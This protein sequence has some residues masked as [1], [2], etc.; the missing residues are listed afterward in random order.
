VK[1]GLRVTRFGCSIVF[2]SLPAL[3]AAQTTAI[4][5]G[6]FSAPEESIGWLEQEIAAFQQSHP[7]I[8]VSV[9]NLA[10]PLR[11]RFQ[12]HEDFFGP[13]VEDV[14]GANVTGLDG[15]FGYLAPYLAERG[16]IASISRFDAADDSFTLSDFYSTQLDFVRFNGET[17]AVPWLA[18]TPLLVI[19]VEV[20]ER[21]G[22]TQAPRT[23]QEFVDVAEA[24]T[25]DTNND[26]VIDQ[27]GVGYRTTDE[28]TP[29]LFM[30]LVLQLDGQVL[31]EGRFDGGDDAVA[32][33]VGFMGKLG[34]AWGLAREDGRSL[35]ERRA[36]PTAR[37]A[38]HLETNH[39]LGAAI[40]DSGLRLAPM[41]S[42]D[43]TPKIFA[44]WRQY[45]AVRTSTPAQEAA[46]W[47]FVKWMTRR[48][49]SMPATLAGFPARKDFTSR[50]DFRQRT[51]GGIQNAG[52]IFDS[53]GDASLSLD[54]V[55]DIAP[56]AERFWQIMVPAIADPAKTPIMLQRARD[57][58]NRY[59]GDWYPYE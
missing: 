58:A 13:N 21:A 14:L 6:W 34:S 30:S 57:S 46:S 25:L 49:V 37:Y 15:Q 32:E 9:K 27:W 44:P 26:G 56:A 39:G 19:D 28:V 59:L 8:S 24:L 3:C 16:L 48:D 38:M 41:P 7:H 4:E 47:E 52:L 10:F 40:N 54:R 20:F 11:E 33:A 35:A 22:I 1:R 5:V 2:F 23:W 17:W 12:T 43:G 45:L 51:N 29:S 18:W 42:L 50:E 31:Q 55:V 53:A 36:D